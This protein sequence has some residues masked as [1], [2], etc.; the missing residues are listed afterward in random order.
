MSQTFKSCERVQGSADVVQAAVAWAAAAMQWPDA[1]TQL[2]A[3]AVCRT[4]AAAAGAP[5]NPVFQ[6]GSAAAP[7]VALQPL[8]VPRVLAEA[9]RALANVTEGHAA[10]EMLLLI[11]S[12]HIACSAWQPSPT[13]QLQTMLP[14]VPQARWTEVRP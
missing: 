12:I 4:V 1:H 7:A 5:L 10:S 9:V 8:L 6:G 3:V 14:N 13:Q 11:R 2:R